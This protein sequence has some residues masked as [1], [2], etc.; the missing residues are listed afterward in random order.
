MN[1]KPY[2][3]YSSRPL[4]TQQVGNVISKCYVNEAGQVSGN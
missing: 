2:I 4:E 3:T 1:T